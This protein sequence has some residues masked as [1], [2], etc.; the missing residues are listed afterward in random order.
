MAPHGARIVTDTGPIFGAHIQYIAANIGAENRRD[1]PIG[2]RDI[3]W[4]TWS[5]IEFFHFLVNFDMS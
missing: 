5:K 3:D 2:Y 4:Q 1:I